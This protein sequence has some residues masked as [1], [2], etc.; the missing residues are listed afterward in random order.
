MPAAL[1]KMDHPCFFDFFCSS[2]VDDGFRLHSDFF[3]LFR[4]AG[5]FFG[6]CNDF[7]VCRRGDTRRNSKPGHESNTD[8]CKTPHHT[9]GIEF[10][11][12]TK[13]GFLRPCK[14]PEDGLGMNLSVG[15]PAVCGS[16][17]SKA[18]SWPFGLFFYASELNVKKDGMKRIKRIFQILQE[19]R[20][21]YGE[22]THNIIKLAT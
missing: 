22:L 3:Y 20:E 9:I 13:R 2:R 11:V 19:E 8:K 17:F 18:R 10:E 1:L 16:S 14:P 4:S 21:L 6:L 5:I 7:S 15:L 12:I